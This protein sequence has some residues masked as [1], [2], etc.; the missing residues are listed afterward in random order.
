[1][2]RELAAIHQRLAALVTGPGGPDVA[3]ELLSI[4][5]TLRDLAEA[6]EE[7]RRRLGAGLGLPPPPDARDA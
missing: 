2:A 3:T 4:R 6:N 7:V 1:V 5:A